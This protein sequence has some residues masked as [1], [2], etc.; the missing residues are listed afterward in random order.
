MK[1][2]PDQIKSKLRDLPGWSVDGDAISRQFTLASFPDAIAFVTRLAF[3]AEAADHHPDLTISYKRVTVKWST[4]S[5]GGVTEKDIEG[6]RQADKA[7][8]TSDRRA[9]GR[10]Y[11]DLRINRRYVHN[12][13]S[14]MRLKTSY[15]AREVAALTGLTARQLQG[16]DAARVFRPAISPRRTDQGGFTE[17]RYTPVDVI[18]LARAGRSAPPRLHAGGAEAA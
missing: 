17:R 13:A 3:D 8:T 6:A 2:Q 7:A 15:S 12:D 1:L 10:R 16:W 9:E 5:E 11:V 18:E 4:H 14:L